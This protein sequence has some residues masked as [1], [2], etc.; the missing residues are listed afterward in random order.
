M[1]TKEQLEELLA[2]S[3]MTAATI[4]RI[5]ELL[6]DPSEATAKA[7]QAFQDQREIANLKKTIKALKDQLAPMQDTKSDLDSKEDMLD[8]L[9]TLQAKRTTKI[10]TRGETVTFNTSERSYKALNASPDTLY[11]SPGTPVTVGT[12]VKSDRLGLCIV[13]G[14]KHVAGR[15]EATI[16]TPRQTCQTWTAT[17]TKTGTNLKQAGSDTPCTIFKDTLTVFG[18]PLATGQIIKCVGSFFEVAGFYKEGNLVIHQLK[19]Y[20]EQP[21]SSGLS[22][23]TP[24]TLTGRVIN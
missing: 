5:K 11:F 4:A 17:S 6:A 22:W 9:Y 23:K 16:W 18:Q 24:I 15:I 19:C 20:G 1:T 8:Q 3:P 12:K 14:F 7:K 2:I 10:E 13:T 21:A